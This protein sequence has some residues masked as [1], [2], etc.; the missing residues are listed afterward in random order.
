MDAIL[1]MPSISAEFD[2]S[3][4]M[5]PRTLKAM[6][7]SMATEGLG[8]REK[9]SL[10]RGQEIIGRNVPTTPDKTGL[11]SSNRAASSGRQLA[12]STMP[13]QL[14][15]GVVKNVDAAESTMTTLLTDKLGGIDDHIAEISLEWVSGQDRDLV[16]PGAVFYLTLYKEIS[17]A[18]TCKNSQEL[19]FRRLPNWSKKEVQGFSAEAGVLLRKFRI[20][21]IATD[22]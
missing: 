1:E 18:G 17:L 5:S 3:G 13:V 20:K 19:R 11:S 15:E 2:Y 22:E 12:P 4:T 21:P 14:W 6:K 9:I 16:Q 7:R 8:E 10:F